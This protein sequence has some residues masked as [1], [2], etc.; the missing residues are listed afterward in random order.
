MFQNNAYERKTIYIY[1][2]KIMQHGGDNGNDQ[3][4]ILFPFLLQIVNGQE[5]KFQHPMAYVH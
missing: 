2:P 4:F 1:S 3:L 5:T